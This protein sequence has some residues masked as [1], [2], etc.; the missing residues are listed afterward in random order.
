MYLVHKFHAKSEKYIKQVDRINKFSG[1]VET[2]WTWQIFAFNLIPDV[3]RYVL[4]EYDP[5]LVSKAYGL[6]HQIE[7]LC[8]EGLAK[9]PPRCIGCW[10]MHAP[11]ALA[12]LQGT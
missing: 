2:E 5:I 3:K 11:W 10:R 12:G 6:F 1:F 9:Y 8:T 7:K 4:Y